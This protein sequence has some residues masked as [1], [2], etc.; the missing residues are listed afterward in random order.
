MDTK[1]H[2]AVWG[3]PFLVRKCLGF[4]VVGTKNGPSSGSRAQVGCI[5]S[6]RLPKG[7]TASTRT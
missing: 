2:L 5:S 4:S 6:M 3:P 1:N 7:S